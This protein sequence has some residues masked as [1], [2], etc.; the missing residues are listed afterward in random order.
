MKKTHS[1]GYIMYDLTQMKFCKQS[2][3]YINPE[4][5]SGYKGL[6]IKISEVLPANEYEVILW[7]GEKALLLYDCNV[8]LSEHRNIHSKGQFYCV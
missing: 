2:N 7:G 5:R 3:L 6:R 8:G 1:Q 4:I